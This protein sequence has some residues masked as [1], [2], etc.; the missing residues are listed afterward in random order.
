V[1]PKRKKEKGVVKVEV[2]FEEHN[3]CFYCVLMP[4]E[5]AISRAADGTG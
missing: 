4:L 3:K 2:T 1:I 5:V